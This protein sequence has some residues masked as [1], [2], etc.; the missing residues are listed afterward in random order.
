VVGD[1]AKGVCSWCGASRVLLQWLFGDRY[2]VWLTSS[3]PARWS[4]VGSG[5]ISTSACCGWWLIC[6]VK[7]DMLL[8]RWWCSN[9]YAVIAW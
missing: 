2:V 3:F 6:E 5:S 1:V 9:D 4:V 7:R 8:W